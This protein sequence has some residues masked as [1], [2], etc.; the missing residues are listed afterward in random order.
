MKA[1]E[2]RILDYLRNNRSRLQ[3]NDLEEIFE[4]FYYKGSLADYLFTRT[5]MPVFKFMNKI[6]DDFMYESEDIHSIVIPGNIKKIGTNAFSRSALETVK[7]ENGVEILG[8][9]CF[10]ECYDLKAIDLPDTISTIPK[11]CFYDCVNLEKVFLPDGIKN[12][13][14]DAFLG[15]EKVE[16]IA[17]YRDKD[18]IRAKKSDYDF[19]KKHLK[20]THAE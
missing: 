15:C 6:P 17:N 19:L 8:Q 2:D 7:L 1:S 20:F 13:G 18:K 10:K 5:S 14:A 9:G 16:I 3:R 12:I 11:D 4:N